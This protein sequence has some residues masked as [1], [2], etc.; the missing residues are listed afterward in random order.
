VDWLTDSLDL[1]PKTKNISRVE[2]SHWR[3]AMY[4]YFQFTNG[5]FE[6]QDVKNV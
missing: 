6:L 3:P 1:L 4:A 2:L 5:T